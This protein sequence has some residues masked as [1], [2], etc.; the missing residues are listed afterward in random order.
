M[1]GV[2]V[3]RGSGGLGIEVGEFIYGK[4]EKGQWHCGHC[5]R[6]SHEGY[7][8]EYSYVLTR[9]AVMTIDIFLNTVRVSSLEDTTN[10]SK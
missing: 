5:R 8:K 1:C 10:H 3:R 9:T 4:E 6:S 2:D 7:N